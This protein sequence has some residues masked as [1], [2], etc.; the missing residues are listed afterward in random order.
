M[1]FAQWG[2]IQRYRKCAKN[3]NYFA[4]HA[5]QLIQTVVHA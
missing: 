4:Y 5:D 1:I 2:I 3:V